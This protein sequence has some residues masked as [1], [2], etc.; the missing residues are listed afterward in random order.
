LTRR[1][2]AGHGPATLPDFAWWS[3]LPMVQARRGVAAA[4]S[5]LR[6]LPGNGRDWWV[7]DSQPPTPT[8]PA[9]YLLPPFDEYLLGYQARR[10]ALD[11][12]HVRRVN[13]GGGPKP[14]LLLDGR[15]AGV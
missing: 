14:A 6:R 9:A 15:V 7:A 4:G 1:Y 10:V 5:I 2:F 3:E 13:A 12:A 11:P 8:P